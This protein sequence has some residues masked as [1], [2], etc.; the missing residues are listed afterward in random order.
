MTN[1]YPV[2]SE[3]T[4]LKIWAEVLLDYGLIIDFWNGKSWLDSSIYVYTPL[5]TEYKVE[6]A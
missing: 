4:A 1:G 2:H 6:I 5:G 3:K